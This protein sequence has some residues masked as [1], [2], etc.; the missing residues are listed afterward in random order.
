MQKSR[1]LSAIG[2]SQYLNY[3]KSYEL[4]AP[5]L[6]VLVTFLKVSQLWIKN[7]KVIKKW[8]V[9]RIIFYCYF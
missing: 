9:M 8:Q 1:S 7:H 4:G 3:V 5:F 6:N 2:P